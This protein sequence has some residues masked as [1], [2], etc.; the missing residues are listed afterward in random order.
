MPL[1]SHHRHSLRSSTSSGTQKVSMIETFGGRRLMGMSCRGAT[2]LSRVMAWLS[3][4]RLKAE[5][6]GAVAVLLGFLA[7]AKRRTRR[8]KDA[9]T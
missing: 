4:N 6:I 9:G 2:V 3:L 5:V 7:L 8:L 1:S